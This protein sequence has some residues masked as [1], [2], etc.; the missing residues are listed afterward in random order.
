MAGT[1]KA[2]AISRSPQAGDG[3]ISSSLCIVVE[4]QLSRAGLPGNG[5]GET[6][7]RA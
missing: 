3:E 1:A 6:E 4:M 2:A 5:A 7:P